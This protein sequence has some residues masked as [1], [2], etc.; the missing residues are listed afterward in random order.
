MHNSREPSLVPTISQKPSF[1]PSIS[2][3]PTDKPSLIPSASPTLSTK[4]TNAPTGESATIIDLKP[5]RYSRECLS[6]FSSETYDENAC[7]KDEGNDVVV[8]SCKPGVSFVI[9]FRICRKQQENISI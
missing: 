4:P 3:E 7:L 8:G 9:L 5:C 2:V 1:V 6:S